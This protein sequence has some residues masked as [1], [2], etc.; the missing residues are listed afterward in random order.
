MTTVSISIGSDLISDIV[1]NGL[2]VIAPPPM[3]M[4]LIEGTDHSC[5][6][7]G[8]SR[9]FKNSWKSARHISA[10]LRDPMLTHNCTLAEQAR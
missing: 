4:A 10:T 6:P 9:L 5:V 7:S 3:G 1:A 2:P 8:R